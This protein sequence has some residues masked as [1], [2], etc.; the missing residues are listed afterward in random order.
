MK[1]QDFSKKIFWEK[2][3]A[4]PPYR[5]SNGYL[6]GIHWHLSST[7]KI[8]QEKREQYFRATPCIGVKNGE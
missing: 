2:R 5:Y 6:N 1:A 4:P 3:T 8:I 7:R